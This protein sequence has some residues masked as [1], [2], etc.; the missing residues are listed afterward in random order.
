MEKTR[1]IEQYL[2][3]TLSQE[4]R[5]FLESKMNKDADFRNLMLLHQ[6]VNESIKD[7]KLQALKA[8]LG[9]I[10]MEY[11]RSKNK[12]RFIKLSFW[13]SPIRLAAAIVF[14]AVL[15]VAM[16]FT[17]FNTVSNEMLYQK[18]YETY[19]AD[20]ISRSIQYDQQLLDKAI[21]EYSQ[22]QYS[23]ALDILNNIVVRD[24]NNY[25]AWFYRGL[26]CLETRATTEAVR[27]FE[28]IPDTW[29]SPLK[30]HRDWYL[31]LALLRH[32]DTSFAVHKFKKIGNEGGYY[33]ESAKKIIRKIK[34]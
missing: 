27:S 23:E 17:L 22:E 19:D 26:A 9:R 24:Q 3:G 28:S 15:G 21:L 33:S 2:D 25:V 32:G 14:L 20:V 29:N 1:L 7:N 6:E 12:N 16:K 5:A 18:Y 4:E 11:S 8:M 10:D 34:K 30:E 13:R 31:G